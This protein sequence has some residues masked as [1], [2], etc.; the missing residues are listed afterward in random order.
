MSR[1][2]NPV[3]PV[4]ARFLEDLKLNGKKPRTQQADVRA[5]RKFTAFLGHPPDQATED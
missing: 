2:L 3:C 5:V 4:A 1:D